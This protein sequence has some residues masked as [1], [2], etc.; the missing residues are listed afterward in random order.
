MG[1]RDRVLLEGVYQLRVLNPLRVFLSFH[2]Q[3][4]KPVDEVVVMISKSLHGL[5]LE[6]DKMRAYNGECRRIKNGDGSGVCI[7]YA[8]IVVS[9]WTTRCAYP[10]EWALYGI[11]RNFES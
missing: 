11:S 9:C 2:L 4:Q 5:S 7:I 8:M 3:T 6:I 1:K 10:I